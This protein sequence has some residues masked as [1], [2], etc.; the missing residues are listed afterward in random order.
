MHREKLRNFTEIF[1]KVIA[2]VAGGALG[3]L[4]LIVLLIQLPPVRSF[5]AAQASS[6]L[7]KTTGTTVEIEKIGLLFPKTISLKNVYIEG[8]QGDTL[9]HA[10]RFYADINLPAILGG[11][12]IVNKVLLEDAFVQI[13]R[14]TGQKKFNYEFIADA[15]S[16]P[17][18]L[19]VNEE[20]EGQDPVFELYKAE[21]K[22]VR[23]SYVDEPEDIYT[24]LNVGRFEVSLDEFNINENLFKID[25][26]DLE[27]VTLRAE[28]ASG[29]Q[30]E[31]DNSHADIKGPVITA[32]EVNIFQITACFADK[33][34]GLETDLLLGFLGL[35][36]IYLNVSGERFEAER[37]EFS[38][39]NVSL[40]MPAGEDDTLA[41]KE[42]KDQ[43]AESNWKAM[44]KAVN[45]SNLAFNYTVIN[46][47]PLKTGLDFNN[48]SISD[49][50]FSA[51]EIFYSSEYI[52][53][54]IQNLSFREKSGFEI[55]ALSTVLSIDETRAAFENF[56]LKTPH[57]RISRHFEIQYPSL[58]EIGTHPEKMF[59]NLDLQ[60]SIISP[61][62]LV[63]LAPEMAQNPF[64]SK[65]IHKQIGL[66][67]TIQ[68]Q[69]ADLSI[70]GF[71]AVFSPS[72]HVNISGKLKGLPDAEKATYLMDTIRVAGT[73]SDISAY[74]PTDMLPENLAV[75]ESFQIDAEFYGSLKAFETVAGFSSTMG[76]I[77]VRAQLQDDEQFSGEILASEIN[78]GKLLKQPETFG[79]TT[80]N[81]K[82]DGKGI[83]PQ[84][85]KADIVAAVEQIEINSYNYNNLTLEGLL[86]EEHFNG[87]V[88]MEDENLN[89]ELAGLFDFREELP[90]LKAVFELNGADL[91]ALNFT[92]EDIRLQG[93][94]EADI[95]GNTIDNFNGD[96][97]VRDVIII[98]NNQT[99]KIDSL[100]FASVRED[101][102]TNYAIESDFL[103]A[104]FK[105]TINPSDIV[106]VLQAHLNSYLQIPEREVPEKDTLKPQIFDFHITVRDPVI[107]TDLLV[108][109]LQ[110]LRPV[111]I[112]GNYDSENHRL[113]LL[114]DVPLIVYNDLRIDS[115]VLDV[116]SDQRRFNFRLNIR[117]VAN[118][119]YAVPN[120]SFTGNILE[121]KAS[122]ALNIIEEGGRILLSLP[123]DFRRRADSAIASITGG[124]II[125]N[126]QSWTVPLENAVVITDQGFLIRDLSLN[127][128]NQYISVNTNGRLA[129]DPIEV[130][131]GNFNLGN[132]S[133][134]VEGDDYLFRGLT[135]GNITLMN[136]QESFVFTSDL[137]VSGLSY[138]G[139]TIGDVLLKADNVQRDIYSISAG[140]TGYGN[141]VKITGTYGAIN[142]TLNFTADFNSFEL[143]SVSGFTED[144]FHDLYGTLLGNVKISG[145]ILDPN[146]SG[147]LRILDAGVNPVALNTVFFIENERIVLDSKGM[148][149]PEF[150]VRDEDD[151]KA[152]ISGYILTANYREMDI[153]LNVRTRNFLALNRPEEQAELYY[154]RILLDSDIKIGGNLDLP[155]VEA[156]VNLLSGTQLTYIIPETQ[157]AMVEQEGIVEFEIF[158]QDKMSDIMLTSAQ[159]DTIRAEMRGIDLR[160]NVSIDEATVIRIIIDESSGDYLEI[161]G[162]AIVSFGIDRSGAM[163]LTGTYEIDQG[164]YQLSFYDLVRREFDI[165]PGSTITWRGDPLNADVNISAAYTVRTSP[166]Q[167]MEGRLADEAD[168]RAYRQQLPF[169]VFLNMQGELLQP[170]ISFNIELPDDRKGAMDGTVN[171]RLQVLNEQ[172]NELNKQVFALLILG[173]FIAEDPLEAGGGGLTSTARSSASRILTQQLNQLAGRYISGVD[174]T[175]DVESYEDFESASGEGRTELQV[176]LSR[177]FL[178]DRLRVEVGGRVDL[179]GERRRRQGNLSDLAGDVAVEYLLSED[180]TYRLRGFRKNEFQMLLEGDIVETGL[181]LIFTRDFNR[182]R[183][184]FKKRQKED[185]GSQTNGLLINE[186]FITE[187]EENIEDEQQGQDE[188]EG[189]ESD[190]R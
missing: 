49:F 1:F 131:F 112:T 8:L 165:Q 84:T 34:T 171:T 124:V 115:L 96:M 98:K 149:F 67:G 148:R 99:Y 30:M 133:A 177:E 74:L 117:E 144:I 32:N 69:M 152:V 176:G 71:A 141:N 5:I 178:D 91:R 113:E 88:K 168:N 126:N 162:G 45:F 40:A 159:Q 187:E 17:D 184:L 9:L 87:T 57:S 37:I 54:D 102:N 188:N 136:I 123:L 12:I 44:V 190:F 134:L 110:E 186:Y 172:E 13:Y 174:L 48:L 10:G 22:N 43:E 94:L 132:I 4:L 100:L 55:E 27:N 41:P 118:P 104:H 28:I 11:N 167:L 173:R 23:V 65:N 116:R 2:Y 164:K 138:K 108:P 106:G 6:Y 95:R 14:R 16:S 68:G 59:F 145:T 137:A 89:F 93:T 107:L 46:K 7:T 154:G 92:E 128:D 140:I 20:Q 50:N 153:D 101:V 42:K 182:I 161:R 78:L 51:E 81:I 129:T 180:G 119:A 122:L 60:G 38:N 47:E 58:E 70:D 36:E 155:L 146:V 73:A 26:L 166:S 143:S 169:L 120:V 157:V 86:Y 189:S 160:A 127:Q 72:M 83:T 179:E 24:S 39:S 90:D 25:F 3:L 175:F 80:F 15:F 111:N 142:E 18:T 151:N 103:S 121:N 150:T 61:F 183:E 139:D 163:S 185:E 156:R 29:D 35:N 63:L 33:N 130:I 97:G 52:Q 21:L 114:A 170:E 158:D 75:P 31:D 85:M 64:V 62:D 76:N 66:H 147:Q 53:S 181:A 56:L 135:N 109:G 125:L 82:A 105:G 77:D 79:F 19:S